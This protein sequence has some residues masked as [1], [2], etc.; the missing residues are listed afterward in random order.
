MSPSPQLLPNLQGSSP[1]ALP[2]RPDSCPPLKQTPTFLNPLGAQ[3]LLEAVQDWSSAFCGPRRA[4]VGGGGSVAEMRQGWEEHVFPTLPCPLMQSF[5]GWRGARE[6]AGA[7]REQ[8]QRPA[9]RK[10]CEGLRK[11]QTWAWAKNTTIRPGCLSRRGGQ[12]G[13]HPLSSRA[14]RASPGPFP[15]IP[16]CSGDITGAMGRG[17]GLTLGDAQE[18]ASHPQVVNMTR[19]SRGP[20]CTLPCLLLARQLSRLASTGPF[21]PQAAQGL[22]M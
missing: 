21:L 2:P 14:F 13:Q 19:L 5:G 16:P 8:S 20:A 1:S 11:R 22:D 18:A 10:S 9:R 15:S 17:D 12:G 3:G 7:G 6:T 4:L